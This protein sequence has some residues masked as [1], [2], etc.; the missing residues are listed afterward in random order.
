MRIGFDIDGVLSNFTIAF[1]TI[2]NEINPNCPVLSDNTKVF[3]WD[4]TKFLPVT[5]QQINQAWGV[6]KNNP[7]FW[8]SLETI[9]NL[10]PVIEFVNKNSYK[11]DFYFIT[12]RPNTG[13]ISSIYQTINWLRSRRI[14]DPQVIETNK[15]G[16]AAKLLRLDYYIDDKVENCNDVAID[17]PK[18]KVYCVDYPFNK[19]TSW[20]IIRVA[21]VIDYV[22]QIKKE[23]ER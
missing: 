14:Q 4:Y 17:N 13:G 18:C 12:N 22:E 7:Y 3:D 20:D 6:I 8:S 5:N 10:N 15:K 11:H 21:S 1:T 19:H 16:T 9:G 23:L 2:L